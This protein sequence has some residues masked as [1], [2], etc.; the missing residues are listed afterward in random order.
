MRHIQIPDR[1]VVPEETF[2]GERLAHDRR[3]DVPVIVDVE[4]QSRAAAL[5]VDGVVVVLQVSIVVDRTGADHADGRTRSGS[6][7]LARPTGEGTHAVLDTGVGV[8]AG[9]V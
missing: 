9:D 5:G 1:G 2:G 8:G 6:R 3:G 4:L 7:G